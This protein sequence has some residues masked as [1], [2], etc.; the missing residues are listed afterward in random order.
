MSGDSIESRIRA[1][2]E[3]DTAINLHRYPIQVHHDDAVRLE[4]TVEDI[5][6]KRRTVQIAHQLAGN[7]GIDDRLR[8]EVAR[9]RPD[10]E[11]RQ[12]VV[13]TLMQE[14]AF[15]ELQ[16]LEE[17]TAAHP[18][19]DWIRVSAHDGVVM[20][21]GVVESLSHRRL[22]E[23]LSWWTPGTADVDNRLHVQPPERD[24]DDEIADVIRMVLE[25][26]PAIAAAQI[27]IGVAD[28]VVSLRG[29]VHSEENRRI[30]AWDCWYIPGVHDVQNQIEVAK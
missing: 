29:W 3:R 8:L 7:A 28:R 22:A 16:L 25:K 5:E 14:P 26:E 10:D 24:S 30:A 13:H 1:A 11:L 18:S 20:L 23:V 4:G 2:L 19:E 12:A 17:R 21:E 6:A 27:Q 9:P 15:V